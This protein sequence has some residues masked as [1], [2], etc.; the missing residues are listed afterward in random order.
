[1]THASFKQRTI[2]LAIDIVIHLAIALLVLSVFLAINELIELHQVVLDIVF[3]TSYFGCSVV[4]DFT[5]KGA[6]IGKKLLK[7]KVVD[8]QTYDN[9]GLKRLF[10]RD[11]FTFEMATTFLTYVLRKRTLGEMLSSSIVIKM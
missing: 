1:M 10:I 5:F 7:L 3:Y 9:I 4:K 8:N 2:A 11:L 6:S